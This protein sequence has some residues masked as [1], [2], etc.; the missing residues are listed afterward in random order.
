MTNSISLSG[1]IP[2]SSSGKTS[3]YS[4]TTG[5]S[6]K[7]LASMLN[8]IGSN[9]LSRVWQIT[10]IPSGFPMSPLWRLNQSIPRITSIPP[11]LSTTKSARNSTPLKLILTHGQPN[12]QLMSPPGVRVNRGVFSSTV[13]IL[14]FSAK[15]EDMNECDAPE[16]NNTVARAE[17]TRYSPSTTP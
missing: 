9:L 13:G 2:G 15:L 6:S 11:D 8:T 10:C 4:F 5:T 1:G 3:G 7:G 12:R 14:C 17:L 16:S